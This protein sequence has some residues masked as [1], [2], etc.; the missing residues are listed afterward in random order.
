MVLREVTMASARSQKSDIN[1]TLLVN[2]MVA[3]RLLFPSV[4]GPLDA[5]ISS[6]NEERGAMRIVFARAGSANKG[7]KAGGYGVGLV[8]STSLRMSLRPASQTKLVISAA[9]GSYVVLWVKSDM[10]FMTS[11]FSVIA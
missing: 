7:A 5:A 8:Y 11:C 2:V 1:S 10:K 6:V 9:Y 4:V 3:K